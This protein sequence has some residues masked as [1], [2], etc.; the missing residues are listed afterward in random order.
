MQWRILYF[1]GCFLLGLHNYLPPDKDNRNTRNDNDNIIKYYIQNIFLM[2]SI[3]WTLSS[4][5]L[6]NTVS[7]YVISLTWVDYD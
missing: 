7:A 2:Y 1:S 6:C 4:A 3:W 5:A